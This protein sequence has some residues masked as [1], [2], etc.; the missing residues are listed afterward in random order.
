MQV[1]PEGNPRQYTLNARSG[2]A[3]LVGMQAWGEL[4]ANRGA[5][6]G[7]LCDDASGIAD[8]IALVK[9]PEWQEAPPSCALVLASR[10]KDA[11]SQRLLQCALSML[12]AT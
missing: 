3:A 5:M 4:R 1:L 8:K 6:S 12:L 2:H 10:Q 11:V 9:L 7:Q